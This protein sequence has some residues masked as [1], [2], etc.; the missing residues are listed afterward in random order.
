[1][2][3]YV[4]LRYKQLIRLLPRIL[5]AV[6]ILTL[7]ISVLGGLLVHR[8]ENQDDRQKFRVALCGADQDPL[9]R[10]GIMALESFDQTRFS[11]QI[12]TMEEAEALQQLHDGGVDAYV[13][14][15]EGFL[16]RALSGDVQTLTYVTAAGSAGV[17]AM[18][19]QEVTRVVEQILLTAQKGSYGGYYAAH[20]NGG[21]DQALDLL[22]GLCLEYVELALVRGNAQQVE[23]LGV[24]NGLSLGNYLFCG[25]TVVLLCL[26]CL[27]FAPMMIQTDVAMNRLLKAG[28][29]STLAQTIA[30][31]GV[32]CTAMFV[33]TAIIGAPL[34]AVC[35][36]DIRFWQLIPVVMVAS[37]ISFL[38]FSCTTEW[39]SGLLL[40]FLAVCGMCFFS[41]CMYP[42]YF[43][44]E[45]VQKLADWLPTGIC[46]GYLAD[47]FTDDFRVEKLVL[48]G[49]IWLAMFAAAC[50]IR[51]CRI[52]QRKEAA[53]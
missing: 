50:W 37:A 45:G 11:V 16:Q 17:E 31:Y 41:G 29:L 25:L 34:I 44:P 8:W 13:T 33:L 35:E 15:P 46:R 3:R 5:L 51:N 53:T 40:Q 19:Q 48:M 24:G 22:N 18:F 39:I 26:L 2:M 36:V 12:L 38:A 20:F 9:I 21:Q 6:I 49:L 4:L 42:A 32:F 52:L 27:P 47:C 28:G 14:I 23:L 30:E 43:F 7:V 1:M 10:L